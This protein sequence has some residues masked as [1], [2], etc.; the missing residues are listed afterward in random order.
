MIATRLQSILV[1]H[2]N[3]FVR[4][5]AVSATAAS[6]VMDPIQQLYLAKLKEYET[7]YVICT[8]SD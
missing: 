8:V 3:L 6:K 5:L 1:R 4:H 7:K 2:R